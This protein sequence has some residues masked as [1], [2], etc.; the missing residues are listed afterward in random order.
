[1][2]IMRNRRCRRL[3][4]PSP[5]RETNNTQIDTPNQGNETLPNF[6][7]NVPKGLGDTNSENQ[8]TEPSLISN[9]I[10]IWTQMFEQKSKDRITKI[11]EE[12][13][14]KLEPILMEINY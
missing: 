10:Q 11:R 1:M 6:N 12:M 2:G 3:E 9:E 14:N 4:T 8:L 5:E 7:V 13:D